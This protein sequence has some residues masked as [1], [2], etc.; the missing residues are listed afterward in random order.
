MNGGVRL[1]SLARP[2]RTFAPSRAG[3]ARAAVRNSWVW[4][5]RTGRVCTCSRASSA[6]DRRSA[7]LALRPGPPTA[8]SSRACVCLTAEPRVP[9]LRCDTHRNRF[10]RQDITCFPLR[11]VPAVVVL[12]SKLA[13]RAQH[14][15]RNVSR[16]QRR[17]RLRSRCAAQSFQ[18]PGGRGRG[19]WRKQGLARCDD[20]RP[21][22][23]ALASGAVI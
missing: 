11:S 19:I 12:A 21:A 15:D 9:L 3:A 2:G 18:L 1:S 10:I 13:G 4:R 17:M 6:A 22:S 14:L 23:R 5:I 7:L 8:D 16:S 20:S